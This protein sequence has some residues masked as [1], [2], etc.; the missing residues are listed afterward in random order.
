MN[1]TQKTLITVGLIGA[2]LVVA[3]TLYKKYGGAIATTAAPAPGATSISS[4][5]TTANQIATGAGGVLTQLGNLFGGHSTT[6]A[7][8]GA[9]ANP[10]ATT[11]TGTSAPPTLDDGDDAGDTSDDDDSIYG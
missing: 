3:Y 9:P 4:G 8:A 11:A 2:G 7:T 1:P 6:A 5:I 10:P